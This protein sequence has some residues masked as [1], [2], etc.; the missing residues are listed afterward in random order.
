MP[1]ITNP[2]VHLDAILTNISIAYMQDPG[3]FI[4]SRVFPNVPVQFQSDR[5]YTFDR[6][7]F[8]RDE[9]K[10][11][12]P[13]TE[14][15][16]S[17]FNLD[18]T[19]TYFAPVVSFHKDVAWQTM[20]NADTV[21]DLTRAAND[22]VM[23]KLM[24][25]KEKDFV[26]NYFRDGV[27]DNDKVGGSGSG[28]ITPW[29]NPTS[30]TPIEDVREGKTTVLE[31]TG[32]EPNTLVLG[33]RVYDALADHPDIVDRIKYSGG[34]GNEN[35]A[36][37]TAR[38]LAQLFDVERV[39]ISNAI[40][41]NSKEGLAESSSFIAGKNA[42]LCYAE[43]SPS[44]MAPSAGYTFSWSGYLGLGND[45]GVATKRIPMDHLE[46]D[47]IEGSMAYDMKVVGKDLGYFWKNIV[48]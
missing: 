38:T 31:T 19:P 25:R 18:N 4:A 22:F 10:I 36:R 28:E 3:N 45:F 21:L 44:L 34:I 23:Q 42:L 26:T 5:Y 40:V 6:A 20:A 14:S 29:S 2:A 41:N 33:R 35:P 30:S 13:G 43:S 9:A 15:A 11:R 39:L 8:N 32:F 17:G 12:A 37:V 1:R 24:I 48:A 16:G 47:R 46:S 7:D 27:W